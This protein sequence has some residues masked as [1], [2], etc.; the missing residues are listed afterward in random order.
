MDR[1]ACWARVHGVTESDTTEATLHARTIIEPQGPPTSSHM[2]RLGLHAHLQSYPLF[3]KE[4]S[5]HSLPRN[6]WDANG[7]F[8][9]EFL[10]TK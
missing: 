8:R 4:S 2:G 9:V 10:E 6:L 7:V 5:N 1:G 3:R